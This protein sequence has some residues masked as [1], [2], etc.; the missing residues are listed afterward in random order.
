MHVMCEMAWHGIAWNGV[1]RLHNIATS[2]HHSINASQH[3]SSDLNTLHKQANKLTNNISTYMYEHLMS[4][5]LYVFG[6]PLIFCHECVWV[7]CGTSFAFGAILGTRE[8][9][10]ISGLIV[11]YNNPV[12]PQVLTFSSFVNTSQLK[13]SLSEEKK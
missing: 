9:V 7:S 5:Y 2:K 6:G 12:S 10:N 4:N 3:G 1:A 13:C 8:N 11:L